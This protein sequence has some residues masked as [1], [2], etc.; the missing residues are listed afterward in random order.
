MLQAEGPMASTWRLPATQRLGFAACV[1]VAAGLHGV[2]LASPGSIEPR[3]VM[4]SSGSRP[5][6]VRYLAAPSARPAVQQDAEPIAPVARQTIAERPVATA[7][8]REPPVA[9]PTPVALPEAQPGLAT[10]EAAQSA[11]RPVVPDELYLPRALLTVAPKA[12]NPVVIDY[13][14]F[15]GETDFYRGEFDLFI[16]ADG[17]VNRVALVTA[18]L[19]GILAGAVHD[20]FKTAS[21]APGERDGLPVPARIRIEVTFDSRGS[22]KT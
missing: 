2:L 14:R 4:G 16:D 11:P 8:Q 6:L 9:L 3:L 19:P 5:V 1:A 15:D 21:F 10:D 22:D 12:L 13:P 20:A 17:K 7:E 18:E